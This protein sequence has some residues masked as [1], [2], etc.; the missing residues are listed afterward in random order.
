MLKQQPAYLN[1]SIDRSDPQIQSFKSLS[2]NNESTSSLKNSSSLKII[3]NISLNNTIN[4]LHN[5]FDSPR[6]KREKEST[7]KINNNKE[8]DKLETIKLKLEADKL[9]KSYKKNLV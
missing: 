5:I 4:T 9:L 3:E 1:Y 6:Y 7:F 8:S 2:N